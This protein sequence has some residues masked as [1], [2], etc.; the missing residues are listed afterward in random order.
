MSDDDKQPEGLGF[1]DFI[2]KVFGSPEEAE[3]FAESMEANQMVEAWKGIK[4][5][6]DGLRSGGFTF[7]QANGVMGAYLY[8]LISGLEGGQ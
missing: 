1:G 3:K 4:E 8:H 6:Y 7:A 5:V 2:D